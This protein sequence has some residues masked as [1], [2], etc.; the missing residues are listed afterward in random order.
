MIAV[1]ILIAIAWVVMLTAVAYQVGYVQS[2]LDMD[3]LMRR[4]AHGPVDNVAGR[5]PV[6]DAEPLPS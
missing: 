2:S 1:A 6:I 4:F 3:G 5:D